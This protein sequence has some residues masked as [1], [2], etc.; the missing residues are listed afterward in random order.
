MGNI[1]IY[2]YVSSNDLGT[3]EKLMEKIKVRMVGSMILERMGSCMFMERLVLEKNR[4]VI[5]RKSI[6]VS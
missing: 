2:F 3:I 1:I 6:K 4:E 5:N